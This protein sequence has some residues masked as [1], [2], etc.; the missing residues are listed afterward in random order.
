MRFGQNGQSS[1]EC[2]GSLEG[3]HHLGC[4][5]GGGTGGN[6]ADRCRGHE[7]FSTCTCGPPGD[8]CSTDDDCRSGSSCCNGICRDLALD[9]SNCGW[10]G[11]T[12]KSDE[13]CWFSSCV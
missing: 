13:I 1:N 8:H 11:Y 4:I 5:G 6:D 2:R 9:P 12:C 3:A 7:P 10:C